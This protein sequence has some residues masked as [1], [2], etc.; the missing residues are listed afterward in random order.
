MSGV[1]VVEVLKDEVQPSL[2][3]AATEVPPLRSSSCSAITF[4]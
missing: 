1:V 2:I 4:A 3:F